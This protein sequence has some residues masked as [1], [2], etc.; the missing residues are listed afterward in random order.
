MN[1]NFVDFYLHIKNDQKGLKQLAYNLFLEKGLDDIGSAVCDTIYLS[2]CAQI[3]D[4][5][6]SEPFS[7]PTL[8]H[9][10]YFFF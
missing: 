1:R 3:A 4:S 2:L 5:I 10:L 6:S 7:R 9:T 8:Y